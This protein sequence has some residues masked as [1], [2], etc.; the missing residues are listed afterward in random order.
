MWWTCLHRHSASLQKGLTQVT[1]TLTS[2]GTPTRWHGSTI[3]IPSSRMHESQTC[4]RN[5][6]GTYLTGF[7][8]S[9]YAERTEI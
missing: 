4:S 2:S 1:L 7:P 9:S 6:Y 8:R 3:S 5:V